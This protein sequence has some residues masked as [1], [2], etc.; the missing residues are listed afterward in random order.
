MNVH[1]AYGKTGLDIT[2]PDDATIVEPRFVAG[3]EDE[4]AALRAALRDPIGAPPLH[5]LV[6]PGDKVI[7]VHSDIT[8]PMPN[9]RVLPVLIDE[10]QAAGI[11]PE[12]ITL[13]N[14]LG[15]HRPQTRDELVDMLGEEIVDSYLCLQ[16]DCWDDDNLIPLGET[17]FGNPV[18]INRHYME[19]D[20]KILTGFIEPHF[21]AG[22]SGG[23]KAV[24]PSIAGVESVLSNHGAEMIGAHEARWGVTHGNPIWDEMLDVATR[25]EPTF[26]L[27]VTINRH[28]QIT[29]IFAGDLEQGHAQGCEFCRRSAMVDVPQA[30][31]IV[32]TSNSG[33]PLDLNLYQSVKGMSAA[34]EVVKAGGAIIVAAEC[35][36]GL[37]DHGEYARLL[38][39]AERPSELLARI[40]SPGF[41]A[42][43]QWQVQI[44]A[45]VQAKA[46]VYVY[47]DGLS[48]EQIR[49]ALLKPCRDI[50]TTLA[51]L[52]ERHGPDASVCVLPEGPQSAPHAPSH[53]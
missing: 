39:S 5:S 15:T 47:A 2:V 14:G 19:A 48:D 4:T 36:D 51:E 46:D 1:L 40:Q 52:M 20:I 17:R 32:I 30:F 43:D 29:G 3:V 45:Q 31:D 37:P 18:R 41:H 50:E 27:N 25:T 6:R 23:P 26:L 11:R 28:R 42:H 38:R 8:R 49:G 44:Q 7:I 13:L 12:E 33:Y 35:W 21:F 16:H 34:A 9:D 53:R 22:F 24:L 10:L